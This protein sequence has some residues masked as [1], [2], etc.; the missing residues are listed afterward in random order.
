MLFSDHIYA[1]G[2]RVTVTDESIGARD[3]PGTVIRMNVGTVLTAI[4][5]LD[6]EYA[7][8]GAMV[9]DPDQIRPFR[10]L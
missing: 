8:Y 9:F 5:R 4:V 1:A 2:Q 7:A 3:E 6:G 10:A